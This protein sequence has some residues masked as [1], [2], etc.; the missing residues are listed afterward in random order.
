MSVSISSKILG[1]SGQTVKHIELDEDIQTVTIYCDRDQRRAIKD[2]ISGLPTSVNRYVR[3][4]VRDLP[5]FGKRCIVELELAQVMT[6]DKRRRME[7]CELVDTGARFT[8]RY[9][10]MISGLCRHLSIQAVSNH[11][12]IRWCA[13]RSLVHLAGWKSL[14]SKV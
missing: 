6:G 2:P 13:K 8:K 4:H 11:L 12:N 14:P 7:V 10:H 3:R 9:C 1:L 5:L